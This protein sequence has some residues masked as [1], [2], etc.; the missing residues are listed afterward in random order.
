MIRM[1]LTKKI[2]SEVERYKKKEVSILEERVGTF[3]S[4]AMRINEIS[5]RYDGCTRETLLKVNVANL[6]FMLS[7]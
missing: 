2:Q 6:L 5:E 4:C 3:V 7:Q 1:E